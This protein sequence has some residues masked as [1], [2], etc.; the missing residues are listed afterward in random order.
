LVD[1]L[2]KCPKTR[3]KSSKRTIFTIRDLKIE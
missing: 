1:N 2:I 3:L